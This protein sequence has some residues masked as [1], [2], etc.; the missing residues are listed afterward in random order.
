MKHFN[1]RYQLLTILLASLAVHGIVLAATDAEL[2][3]AYQNAIKDA[4]VAEASE[5]D[6]NLTPIAEDTPNLIW[7]GEGENRQVLLASWTSWTGYDAMV[8]KT[9]RMDRYLQ[10]PVR[11]AKGN[12]AMKVYETTRDIWV[13]VVPQ[14]R[15]FCQKNSVAPGALTL[16]L[17]Q[18]IG[19][20]PHNGNT[21]FVEFWVKPADLFRPAPDPDITTRSASLDFPAGVSDA[22]KKW[23]EDLKAVSYLE[24]GY[25]WTRL[26]YT[27]DWG[28]TDNHVGLTEY[29]IRVGALV[30]V[31]SSSLTVYY[32]LYDSYVSN[33]SLFE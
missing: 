11:D 17:E 7:R 3:Q 30:D 13:T 15:E 31:H 32:C 2:Q 10:A 20:P 6:S 9:I 12:T 33:W 27:Y 16:R 18:L 1:T 24:N 14:V 5:I 29:V 25:P 28:K 21:R 8:G 19:L 4:E 26:G 23:I 22:H